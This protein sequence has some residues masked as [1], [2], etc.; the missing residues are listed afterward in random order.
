MSN[1]GNQ[2][3]LINGMN[4][5]VIPT[6]KSNIVSVG[7]FIKAGTKYETKENNGIAHFLEHMLFQGTRKRS[8]EKIATDLDNVGANYNASTSYEFTFYNIQGKINN[9]NLFNDIIIDIYYNSI[10]KKSDI[11][12]E[13]K[14]VLEEMRMYNDDPKSVLDEI[15][16]EKLY[17]GTSL[18]LPIIG[19][20]K[21][22]MKFSKK[23]LDDFKNT[24]Y[25]DD[26]S[27]LVFIGDINPTKLFSNLDK[28]LKKYVKNTPS[29]CIQQQFIIAKQKIPYLYINYC[30]MNQTLVKISF[31]TFGRNHPYSSI[32]GFLEEVLSS[33]SSSR[34]FSLLRNKLAATYFNFVNHDQFKDFGNFTITLGVYHKKVYEVIAAVLKELIKLKKTL[35]SI[36]E[37]KKIINIRETNDLINMESS[38]QD[39]LIGYGIEELFS[40][41]I[42]YKIDNFTAKDIQNVC[43]NL[44]IPE[45][46]NIFIMGKFDQKKKLINYLENFN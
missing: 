36:K 38:I 13:K 39:S 42:S 19:T 4:C 28:I 29:T 46:L 41:E 16:H 45:N 20:E 33:G 43:K 23:D 15:L 37:V 7:M 31:R 32:I 40:D 30:D 12:R 21:N 10:F 22:I 26:D 5:L 8:K 24:F 2:K 14:V 35:I 44:F 34:L 11:E 27:V 1:I 18:E 6:K 9:L 25:R 3:I 17:K